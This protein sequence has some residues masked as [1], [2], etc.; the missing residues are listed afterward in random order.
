ME[1]QRAIDLWGTSTR[2]AIQA[3]W[4]RVIDFV[5][6][7]VGALLIVAVGIIV[8]FILN[9]IVVQILRAVKIQSWLGEQTGFAGVLKKAKLRYDLAE[10]S[11]SFVKWLTILVFIIPA[12]EVL[13]LTG[14]REFVESILTYIP[15]T[16]AVG[17]LVLFG[18]QLTDVISR[19][20]RASLEG[21]G[22]TTAKFTEMLVRSSL[23]VFI[24]LT[25]MFALGVPRQF[26]F[27]MFIGLVAMVAIAFGLSF[28]LGTQR[29]A[30]DLVKKI[31][32]ELKK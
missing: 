19:V 25:A 4:D 28:G 21:F 24:G 3:V 13:R 7:L 1:S 32:D 22:V 15:V 8:A 16:L 6:N 29:H 17:L 20:V 11:G 27:T 14:V 31:R 10:I 12:S 26:G 18:S 2:D 30:D 9:Y 23:Y 5:P